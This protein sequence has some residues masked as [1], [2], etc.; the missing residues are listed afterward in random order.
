MMEAMVATSIFLVVMYGVYV[1]YDVG[2]KNYVRGSRKWDVQSQARVAI[3]RMARET[4]MAGHASPKLTDPIVIATNDTL[5]FHADTDGSGAK[6]ITYS[7]RDCSGN[8]GTTLFRNVY[9]AATNARYCGG[10]AFIDNINSLTFTFY[11]LNNVSIPY[12]LTSTYQLDSQA[13]TTGT[14]AP[15][16]PAAA[17]QRDRVR[18]VK[19]TLT[20]SETTGGTTMPFTLSTDVALRNLLP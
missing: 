19:I 4:R 3:E 15:T 10:D 12:P 17:G 20:V 7:R 6:Y 18:Q 16:T 11:E 1:I 2:E 9:D 13:P 14:A 5:A 8:I